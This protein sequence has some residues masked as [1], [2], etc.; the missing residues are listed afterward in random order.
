M[1]AARMQRGR[2]RIGEELFLHRPVKCRAARLWACYRV[3]GS[4]DGDAA[5]IT[6][7]TSR[8]MRATS[9]VTAETQRGLR[10]S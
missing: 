7:A 6:M 8:M 1:M 4:H 3:R 10:P 2:A 5:V 9:R